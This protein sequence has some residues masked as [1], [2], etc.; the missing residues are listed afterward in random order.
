[1]YQNGKEMESKIAFQPVNFHFKIFKLLS[2]FLSLTLILTLSLSLFLPFSL[3]HFDSSENNNKNR[4]KKS[5]PLESTEEESQFPFPKSSQ[6]FPKSSHFSR[7]PRHCS[8]VSSP[9]LFPS[10][11]P[12]LPPPRPVTIMK[13]NEVYGEGNV[14]KFRNLE[15]KTA[16][17]PGKKIESVVGVSGN[18]GSVRE[19]HGSVREFR[20]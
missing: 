12:P 17:I 18:L 13:R 16:G 4:F 1:M 6:K 7:T 19:Y 5:S 2:S 11:T 8:R 3:S 20:E 10:P 15:T 14:S 9:I